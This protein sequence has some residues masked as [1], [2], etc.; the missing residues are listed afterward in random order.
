MS[1]ELIFVIVG[2]VWLAGIP[3][4][5]WLSY[6]FDNIGKLFGHKEWIWQWPI[7]LSCYIAV[8]PF[9]L[10][11]TYIVNPMGKAFVRFH[12]R[13]YTFTTQIDI[14]FED[15]RKAEYPTEEEINRGNV[16]NLRAA[17]KRMKEV[18]QNDRT[19]DA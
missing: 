12:H 19:N 10:L 15:F 13:I 17:I 6:R 7:A 14:D 5:L 3:V 18:K 2:V 8:L 11:F 9:Y 1:S 16:D 4:M